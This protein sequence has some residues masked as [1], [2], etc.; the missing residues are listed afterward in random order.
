M[1]GSKRP[2]LA[3]AFWLLV[4]V[5]SGWQLARTRVVADLSAFLPPSATP[6][7]QLLLEQM[8]SGVASRLLLV[9]VGG[10]DE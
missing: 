3:V 2:R 6:A 1:M 4:L 10:A 7:Q 9:A 8:R 5:V